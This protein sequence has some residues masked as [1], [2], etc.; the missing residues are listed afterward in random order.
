MVVSSIIFMIV[1]IPTW[2]VLPI[3][4][5]TGLVTS[6]VYEKT[7]SILPAIIIHGV[8]NGIALI[9]TVLG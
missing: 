5:I 1:H 8:F 9:L 4:F 7:H 6:W 2:N 3:A